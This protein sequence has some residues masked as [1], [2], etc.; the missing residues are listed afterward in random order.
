MKFESNFE[1]RQ[2]DI[3]LQERSECHCLGASPVDFASGLR[4][5]E[6][7]LFVS[8]EL[9]VQRKVV[10][11]VDRLGQHISQLFPL[12]SGIPNGHVVATGAVELRPRAEIARQSLRDIGKSGFERG[13]PLG[14]CF[15]HAFSNC[16]LIRGGKVF[17]PFVR[18]RLFYR[19][20]NMFVQQRIRNSKILNKNLYFLYFVFLYILYKI[21]R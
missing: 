20:V 12:D 2:I 17:R 18:G 9:S 7:L 19:L 6:T 21:F 5:F 3:Y 16:F 13:I 1:S 8:V 4:G 15:F 10:R 14:L 11:N